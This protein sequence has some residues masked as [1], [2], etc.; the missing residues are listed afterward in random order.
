MGTAGYTT[1]V[2]KGGTPTAMVDEA[3][4]LVSGFTYEIVDNAKQVWDRDTVPTFEDGGSPIAAI[5]IVSI[6]YLLGQVTLVGAPAGAVTVSGNYIPIAY[7]AGATTYN[8]NLTLN[9]L[10]DTPLN[11]NVGFQTKQQGLI[12]AVIG[13]ERFDEVYYAGE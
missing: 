10:V 1:E 12:D 4:S 11:T 5:D 13:V 3:M 6:N 2:S 7:I 9:V 8:V